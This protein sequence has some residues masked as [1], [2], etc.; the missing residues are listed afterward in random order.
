MKFSKEFK[1]GNYTISE[2]S[3]CYII[4]EIGSN[5]NQSLGKAK[6]LICAAAESGANAAKFQ[7]LNFNALY[8]K[9]STNDEVK[10]L[11]KLIELS[12]DWYS[13][14]QK[15]CKEAGIDFLSAPTYIEALSLLANVGAPA[16]KIASPQFDLYPEITIES[17]KYGLP[18]IMSVGLSSLGEI[19]QI[20]RLCSS[21]NIK[22]IALLHCVSQYPTP[23][24]NANL[25]FMN[26]LQKIYG[27]LVGYSD[28]T[29]G[30]HFP[31]SAVAMG[32]KI[33]EKH[34]TLDSKENGPDHHF[35]T[36]PK[37]FKYMVSCIRDI[38]S[39][40][41]SSIKQELTD[42]EK[43]H[44]E[45]ISMKFVASRD[46]LKDEEFKPE[47]FELKRGDGGIP[48]KYLEFLLSAKLNKDIMKGKM[49][50]WYDIKK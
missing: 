27:C 28:H 33:I 1:I 3:D 9:E 42:W 41:G 47:D 32:A 14:L 43:S 6:E 48:R 34:F 29:L 26:T 2:E 37:E 5:H 20:M 36:E 23:P 25:K 12:H 17:K 22:D 40:L 13:S 18:L 7:S 15:Q 11:F 21:H 44:K 10:S 31:I 4:A 19:D 38:E 16:F 39:G 45:R 8:H 50:E 46:L 35:A 24:E 30:T 49:L